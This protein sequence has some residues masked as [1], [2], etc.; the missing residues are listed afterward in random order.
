MT[1]SLNLDSTKLNKHWKA[2]LSLTISPRPNKSV[3]SKCHHYGPL[4]VQRPFYPESD[5][6]PHLYILHPPGGF[7]AGDDISISVHAL[8]GA[9]C[10]LTTPAA[11]KFYGA[12][13]RTESQYQKTTLNIDSNASIEWL[14]QETIV[15]DSAKA[16]NQCNINV[17]KSSTL[18]YWETFC[19]GRLKSGE[20]FSSGFINQNIQIYCADKLIHIEKN[21]LNALSDIY[22]SPAGFNNQPVFGSMISFSAAY[23]LKE[24]I[25]L[26]E[27]LEKELFDLSEIAKT[28]EQPFKIALTQKNELLIA[29]FLGSNAAKAQQLYKFIWQRLRPIAKNVPACPPRIWNT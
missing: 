10:L 27:L 13:N 26:I 16:N 22:K 1:T 19:L 9:Q 7:V 25:K 23:L 5:L 8:S 28:D 20:T 6:C 12:K 21:Q 17:Q 24:N 14:P 4:R 18:F 2:N 11:G 29:R 15:F 3:L